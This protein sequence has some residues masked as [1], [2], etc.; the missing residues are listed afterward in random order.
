[1][2]RSSPTT[3]TGGSGN[4][5]K[6]H[7]PP[8]KG[9][10]SRWHDGC[11][12][13]FVW[14]GVLVT[15]QP[16][17]PRR[18]KGCRFK[19]ARRLP[20]QVA[21]PTPR[22]WGGRRAGAGRTPSGVRSSVPHTPRPPHDPRNPVHVTLRAVRALA[23][24]RSDRV[25]PALSRTFAIAS[26]DR[27]RLLH[28]SVQTDHLHLIVEADGLH[29][30]RRG[31]NRLAGLAARAVNRACRRSGAIWGERY[32]AR[33]LTTPREVRNGLVYVLLN[34]RKHLRAPPGIDPRSSGAWFDGWADDE[35]VAAGPR[36]VV[37]ARSWLASV[38]WRR[39]GG[40]IS[41]RETPAGTGAQGSQ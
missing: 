12:E 34:F 6:S 14:S 10:D 1:M 3:P 35:P 11:R 40:P 18:R 27:F 22:T 21:L 28:F 36:P 31:L 8:R 16:R 30:L 15:T 23:S 37:P 33:A 38:G 24:L 39:A 25:F 7:A 9:A 13:R 17:S 26:D 32:H 29:D 5:L 4:R 41:V 19:M 2:K 20:K